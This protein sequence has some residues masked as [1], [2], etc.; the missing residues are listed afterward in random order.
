[1]IPQTAA[2]LLA[3]PAL[4]APGIVFENLRER[5]RPSIEQTTFREISGI[6][7]ASLYFTVLSLTLLAGLRAPN[8]G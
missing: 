4:V 1:V 3:F 6:A 2:A 7:L 5:R 8:Q